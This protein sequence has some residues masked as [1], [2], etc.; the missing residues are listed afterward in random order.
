MVVTV[1]LFSEP[2]FPYLQ[3]SIKPN[4]SLSRKGGIF[5]SSVLGSLELGVAS[6]DSRAPSN[7]LIELE[8]PSKSLIELRA[9]SKTF[10]ELVTP[11]KAVI[12]LGALPKPLVDLGLLPRLLLSEEIPLRLSLN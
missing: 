1:T 4:I 7:A 12:D 3:I 9:P 10:N 11:S 8:T 6:I 5:F 2:Q